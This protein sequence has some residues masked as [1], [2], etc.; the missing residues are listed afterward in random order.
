MEGSLRRKPDFLPPNER[1]TDKARL[2]G[3]GLSRTKSLFTLVDASCSEDNKVHSQQTDWFGSDIRCHTGDLSES[4]SFDRNLRAVMEPHLRKARLRRMESREEEHRHLI[5]GSSAGVPYT[6]LREE[7]PFLFDT[8]SYPMHEILAE[9]LGVQDLSKLHEHTIQDK[10]ELLAPLLDPTSRRCFHEC[11]DKFVTTFII[12][13]V[14]SFAMQHNLLQNTSHMASSKIVYRYQ[15]FPN[16]RIVRP[17]EGSTAPKCDVAD[18]H[19]IGNLNFHIPLTPTF[20]TN[21]VYT[22][23]HVGREDWHPL[24][25]KSFGLGYLFD[26]ARCVH[27]GLENTTPVTCVSIDFRVAIYRED[28]SNG[29][30]EGGGLCSRDMLQ[31]R[32]SSP[33]YY[34]EAV[35]ETGLGRVSYMQQFMAKKKNTRR[36]LEPDSR[37][38]FP[39]V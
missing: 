33:G 27:F 23:S 7:R 4:P 8:Y 17:G 38:G 13:L 12:P 20:G 25:A 37:V 19:S 21:S 22:E 2:D 36:L 5:I 34:E 10:Q 28:Y 15:A 11:Y 18:G 29:F 3:S 24:T 6:P 30:L 26:G 35:V 1:V 39:F 31:D 32:F 9:T 16:I 14:H